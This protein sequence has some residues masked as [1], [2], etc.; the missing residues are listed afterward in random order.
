M[1]AVKKRKR[2]PKPWGENHRREAEV[3]VYELA[4]QEARTG[5]S[6]RAHLAVEGLVRET[7]LDEAAFR[8]I[9]FYAW[10]LDLDV[11][12]IDREVRHVRALAE[13]R[14]VRETFVAVKVDGVAYKR[15]SLADARASAA[16]W[17]SDPA[18]AGIRLAYPVHVTRIRRAT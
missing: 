15:V 14:L 2:A 18:H 9:L 10:G 11:V 6:T 17:N 3:R 7:E 5:S 13:G 4:A 16:E 1:S 12:T 8:E